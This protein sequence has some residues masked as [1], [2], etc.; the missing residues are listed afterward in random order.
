MDTP[1]L[2]LHSFYGCFEASYELNTTQEEGEIDIPVC[3]MDVV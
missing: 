2:P 1:L 3:P